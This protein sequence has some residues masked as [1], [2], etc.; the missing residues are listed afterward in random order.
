MPLPSAFAVMNEQLF[1]DRREHFS[2]LNGQ[3]GYGGQFYESENDWVKKKKIEK[4]TSNL[5][6]S[7]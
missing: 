7:R 1:S 3:I 5:F 6:S 4:L 2:I